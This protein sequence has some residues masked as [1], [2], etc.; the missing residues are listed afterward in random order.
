[1][2]KDNFLPLIVVLTGCI[3]AQSAFSNEKINVANP[4]SVELYGGLNW[5]DPKDDP[6]SQK[7]INKIEQQLLGQITFNRISSTH[8]RAWTD[9]KVNNNSCILNVIK[10]PDRTSKATYSHYPLS[11]S[12]PL[13][14]FASVN[15]TFKN[16]FSFEQLT[17]GLHDRK[18][19][20]VED[21]FYSHAHQRFQRNHPEFFYIHE[22]IDRTERLLGM[23]GKGRIDGFMEY[24]EKI[25]N[26]E[27]IVSKKVTFRVLA[28]EGEQHFMAGFFACSNTG[29]GKKIIRLI[30]HVMS[31]KAFRTWMI[32]QHKG[33]F[34]EQ[35]D[36]YLIPHLMNDIY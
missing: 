3:M 25:E 28:I 16:P 21:R 22:S 12:P 34:G 26:A 15:S 14:F 6:I 8:Q 27:Q 2:F 17:K 32:E 13:R 23:L 31:D 36:K 7:I 33:Y 4:I 35:E 10:T 30:D 5:N 19:A 29:N 1:M 24:S 20:I 9:L 11:V 18:I